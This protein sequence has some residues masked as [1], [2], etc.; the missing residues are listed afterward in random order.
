M[1]FFLL[2]HFKRQNPRAFPKPSILACIGDYAI[3]QKIK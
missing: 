1:D 2:G 3:T